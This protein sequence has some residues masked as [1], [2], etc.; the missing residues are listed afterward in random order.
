MDADKILITYD[1]SIDCPIYE[2]SI[3]AENVTYLRLRI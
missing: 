1:E 2:Q 3:P